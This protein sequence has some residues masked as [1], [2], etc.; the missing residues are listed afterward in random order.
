MAR[1]QPPRIQ[2]QVRR[3]IDDEYSSARIWALGKE[4]RA[5]GSDMHV[6]KNAITATETRQVAQ[7]EIASFF[8][9]NLLKDAKVLHKV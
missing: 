9:E 2:P 7:T 3:G 5:M 4:P 8:L 1:R 6:V